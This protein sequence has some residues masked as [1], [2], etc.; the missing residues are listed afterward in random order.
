MNKILKPL[1]P[2]S[3]LTAFA[4]G[5]STS[6]TNLSPSEEVMHNAT[7]ISQQIG[8]PPLQYLI[9]VQKYYDVMGDPLAFGIRPVIERDAYQQYGHLILADN[10]LPEEAQSAFRHMQDEMALEMANAL[11]IDVAT[12]VRFMDIFQTV[13]LSN[14]LLG[15]ELVG[16]E[17]IESVSATEATET[18]KIEV[19]CRDACQGGFTSNNSYLQLHIHEQ[20]RKVNIPESTNF[21]QYT[22][23]VDFI[24]ESTNE[25][26]K[27][28]LW[29]HK[30][31][32]GGV[33]VGNIR[34]DQ[35]VDY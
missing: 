34:I 7:L 15:A 33:K 32:H 24:K 1:I 13:E 28:E 35:H 25:V 8:I 26:K 10:M 9:L 23:R 18:E 16:M 4:I 30:A 5:A 17:P 6:E 11:N 29:I 20:A 31:S 2:I 21:R 27:S 3:L 12:Y 14:A 19:K 22:F